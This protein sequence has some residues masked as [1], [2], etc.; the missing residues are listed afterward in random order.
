MKKLFVLLFLP[1]V[2]VAF[3]WEYT[4][5]FI[6]K[7]D[8]VGQIN[9]IKRKDSTVRVLLLRWTLYQNGRLVVLAKY[10]GFPT[11]YII[12]KEYK[13]NS[14]KITL[15]DDYNVGSKRCYL[16]L[17]FK[18]FD[19]AKKRALIRASITDPQKRIEIKFVDPKK[20]KG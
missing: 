7:K 1:L 16:I 13:R 9:V 15:R 3:K 12:Q 17:T 14:I 2:L 18:T 11:Q 4:H 8:E 10:D 5:D 19:D 20:S 6:L